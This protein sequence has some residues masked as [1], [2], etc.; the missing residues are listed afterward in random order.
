MTYEESPHWGLNPGPYAYEA[1]ALPLSYRGCWRTQ[2]GHGQRVVELLLLLKDCHVAGMLNIAQD[3]E[4]TS[5]AIPCGVA[6]TMV[7]ALSRV[8]VHARTASVRACHAT[9]P[10]AR[11]T[12]L[13]HGL[14][15]LFGVGAQNFAY[16]LVMARFVSSCVAA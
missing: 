9:W 1:H 15:F 6:V 12:I 13:Q 8:R 16:D 10:H 14:R 3:H 4:W 2:L 11:T 5:A 7:G